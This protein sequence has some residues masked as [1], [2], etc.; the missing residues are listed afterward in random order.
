M[1]GVEGAGVSETNVGSKALP[2]CDSV[3]PLHRFPVSLE[4]ESLLDAVVCGPEQPKQG[5]RFSYPVVYPR[6]APRN[7]ART[8]R[9][10]P[11]L[12]L[13]PGLRQ[14]RESRAATGTILAFHQESRDLSLLQYSQVARRFGLR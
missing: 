2:R 8:A 9:W 3:L 4:M 5:R 1:A 7:T 14:P 6:L 10:L 12:R 13:T 11:V